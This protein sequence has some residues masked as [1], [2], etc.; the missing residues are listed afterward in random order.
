MR[1]RWAEKSGRDKTRL[2]RFRTITYGTHEKVLRDIFPNIDS[3]E[4]RS[5][6]LTR[7]QLCVHKLALAYES[8][9]IEYRQEVQQ[10]VK[11][12]GETLAQLA[13][14]PA[15]STR[16]DKLAEEMS[17]MGNLCDGLAILWVCRDCGFFC[18]SDSW[19]KSSSEYKF[20][21]PS[22]KV[23]YRPWV[24]GKLPF[25]KVLA[26]ETAE[27]WVCLPAAMKDQNDENFLGRMCMAHVREKMRIGNEDL[28]SLEN[29]LM[30][31]ADDLSKF[32]GKYQQCGALTLM[33]WSTLNE[34]RLTL[35]N[36]GPETYA[37]LKRDGIMGGFV[38]YTAGDHIF[39]EYDQIAGLMANVIIASQKAIAAKKK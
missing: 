12:Y 32:L 9:S 20:R 36:Y 16:P 18:R 28:G 14:N 3:R 31:S 7:V 30:R 23:V 13:S 33:P 10:C 17:Y 15:L 6:I 38:Q 26:V 29:M 4:L 24:A 8:G 27:G 22:C 21:C 39:E 5:L 25:Q 35:P 1:T 2:V 34:D 19:I 37:H 11:T